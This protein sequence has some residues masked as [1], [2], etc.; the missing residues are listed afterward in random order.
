MHA[1]CSSAHCITKLGCAPPREQAEHDF[2]CYSIAVNC[3]GYAI[4]W[5]VVSQAMYCHISERTRQT[6]HH[7]L[8]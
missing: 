2:V 8:F 3:F 6:Q 7:S 5:S 4:S 1:L